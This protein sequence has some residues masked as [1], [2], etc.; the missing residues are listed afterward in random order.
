MRVDEPMLS[1]VATWRKA[2]KRSGE[3][4][5]KASQRPLNSSISAISRSISCETDKLIC[6]LGG[7]VLF[8]IPANI[9]D[10]TRFRADL[11]ANSASSKQKDGWP[12]SAKIGYADERLKSLPMRLATGQQ[13]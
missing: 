11:L 8:G 5:C 12:F 2:R 10:F 7:A 6:K 3:S 13:H 4:V 9:P 1:M